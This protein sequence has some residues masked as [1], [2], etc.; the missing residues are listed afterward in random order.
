[1]IKQKV[2]III[3]TYSQDELLERNI[4][5]IEDNNLSKNYQIYL[6]DDASEKRIGK[7][8]KENFPSINLIINKE[9]MGFSKS[10]NIGITKAKEE[11]NPDLF[12][13]YNDDCEMIEENFIDKL[14]EKTKGFSKTGI[15]GCKLIYK[16]GS[17]QWGTKKG[18]NYF[19]NEG[20]VKEIDNEF[21]QT[22]NTTEII[23]AFMLIKK[24][25]FE[26]IGIFD[27]KF[28]PFYGEES[29]L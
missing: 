29:D 1:M 15:F 16:D 22:Q 21:S 8:M 9:N 12:L 18:K 27:E 23:G 26:E 4:K 25:L 10:N 3:T 13:I 2:A 11:Y 14:L 24:E 7:K 6:V 19:F 17:I 28:S 20:E 5:S